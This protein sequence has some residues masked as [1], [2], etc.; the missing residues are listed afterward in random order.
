M[1]STRFIEL[2]KQFQPKLAAIT[3]KE[4]PPGLDALVAGEVP[5]LCADTSPSTDAWMAAT[6]TFSVLQSVRTFFGKPPMSQSL[7]RK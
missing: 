3:A 2:F 6:V 4:R 5:Y 7:L 1:K